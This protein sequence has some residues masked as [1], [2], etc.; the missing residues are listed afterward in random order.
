MIKGRQESALGTYNVVESALR[1]FL[2]NSEEILKAGLVDKEHEADQKFVQVGISCL[3]KAFESIKTSR[4]VDIIATQLRKFAEILEL[5]LAKNDG[6][7][8]A[9]S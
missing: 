3:L 7:V 1:V 5:L 2:G 6:E 9:V 8:D 4:G